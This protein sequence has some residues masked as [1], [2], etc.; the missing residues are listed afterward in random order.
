MAEAESQRREA[1]RANLEGAP[2]HS[3]PANENDPATAMLLA[4]MRRRPSFI[5]YAIFAVIPTALWSG[6]W[7]FANSSTLSANASATTML[8]ALAL[9]LVPVAVI[10]IGAF[11]LWRAADMRQVSEALFQSAMRLLRP[12]DI[13][14][15]GLTSIAQ[16]VRSEVDLLVGG[17][18]QSVVENRLQTVEL[19]LGMI[20]PAALG[21]PVQTE[22]HKL[23]DADI[24]QGWGNQLR[25]EPGVL[26]A[27]LEKWRYGPTT[28][29]QAVPHFGVT[30]G[31]VMTLARAGGI[32][33]FGRNM[34]GFGPDT[35]EPGG[36]MLQR[37]RL[38][39]SQSRDSGHEWYLF[40]G[41]DARAVARNI[42]LDGN[43]FRDSA[44][45]DKR[46][47]VYDFKAGF[48]MRIA[49]VRVSLTHVQRS[50]EFT[51][52]LGK[53]GVQRFQ[54]LNVSWEF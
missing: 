31:N 49:P 2:L 17:V 30:V 19:D 36:A 18:A 22:W 29:V 52:P 51:T 15:E 20:G 1:Q 9:L 33:R 46:A 39:D 27:Y 47:F 45:V 28:G 37:T 54:S 42:F 24:P 41:V 16:A 6:G 14:T 11:T 53:S 12:Q 13:A 44:S 26:L 40:A 21:K 4:K 48:S 25:N 8:Q 23:V 10:W 34:S 35:I 7:F 5:P 32:V 43:T 50:P 38:T 3:R